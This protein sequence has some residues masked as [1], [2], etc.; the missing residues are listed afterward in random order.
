L[1]GS[2]AFF[3]PGREYVLVAL[4]LFLP[5]LDR[6][7]K[8]P[9][10]THQR[11]DWFVWAGML[12]VMVGLLAWQ[13]QFIGFAAATLLL[14]ALPEEWFFRAYFMT[15]LDDGLRANLVTS[16]LFSF[17]HG[18][19]RGWTTALLVFFPSLFYGWLY[20]TKRNLPM[21]IAIHA[22]SNLILAMVLGI[23]RA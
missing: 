1:L 12:L 20:Q 7:W 19:T 4:M 6:H 21:L 14:A 18:L 10:F 11:G 16:L 22:L 5:L 9:V 13:K 17:L 15:R 23:G 3:Y 8:L 2:A